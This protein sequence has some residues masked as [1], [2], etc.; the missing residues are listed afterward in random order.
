M[1]YD[2]ATIERL[3]PTMTADERRLL[4]VIDGPSRWTPLPGPQM[5]AYLSQADELFYG[6]S[7]GG[8]K[9]DLLL[10]LA[11]TAHDR[12]VIFR[13]EYRQLRG[14]VDRSRELF[15]DAG[16]FNGQDLVWR[17]LAGDRQV[18]FGAVQ[19]LDDVRAWQGRP[20]DLKCFDELSNF[21]EGQYRF[22]IA[23]NRTTRPGQRC[24]VVSAG[25]PPTTP[26]GRW[27]VEHWAPWLDVHHPNP[28]EPGELRWFA[29]IDRRDVEVPDGTPFEHLGETIRPRSRTFIPARLE[30]NP[31]LERTGYRAT[32]QAMPEPL[33]SQMLY[34]DFSI[35]L[36]DDPWQVIPTAWVRAAQTRWQERP[37][38]TTA[39]SAIGMDVARGGADK[40]V[41]ARRHGTWFAALEKHDGTSTPDGVVAAAL[42]L[43]ALDNRA[44][45]NV[46]AIGVGAS[47]YDQLRARTP[48]VEA[49]IF[50][51]GA[52]GRDRANVLDFANLRAY[53]YWALRDALDP[54]TG[55]DLA[56][57]PDPELLADLCAPRWSMRTTGVL[58]ESKEDI[59]KRL[60]R[61]P[62]CG[63]AV[64]LAHYVAPR[65]SI[66]GA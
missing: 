10:G 13:R 43:R 8:G 47:V 5:R 34:G 59:V 17:G 38:P 18:E 50:S 19:F 55:D 30:D 62:D 12:S 32:L 54:A 23:W 60:G 26:E 11:S 61:S 65:V 52:P 36:D 56:L 2:Q 42:V 66:W 49:V 64:V 7:A 53:A 14:L 33:R 25:N 27:V 63:D 24:R 46:D 29:V 28:A 31:Y 1:T 37:Q 22:L 58:V 9:S 51:A 44:T 35:G 45:I 40:T 3:L 4:D 48:R 16:H 21:L 20:H 39:L 41:L 6:G 57:P 15:A